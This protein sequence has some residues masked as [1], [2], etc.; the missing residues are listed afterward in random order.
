MSCQSKC[1]CTAPSATAVNSSKEEKFSSGARREVLEYKY[2]T[3]PPCAMRRLAKVYYEGAQ[4]YGDVNWQKGIPSSNLI[5]H[6]VNHLMLWL[7]G[8]RDEDH[9]AKVV[10]GMFTL[11]YNESKGSR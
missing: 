7:E 10:W 2:D 4:R 5:N 8:N 9:L 6:A 11:M 1:D 3:I